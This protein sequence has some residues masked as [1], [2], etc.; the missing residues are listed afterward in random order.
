[1]PRRWEVMDSATDGWAMGSDD[2]GNKA[3]DGSAMSRCTARNGR[4]FAMDGLAIKRWTAKNGRLGN[5]R[6]DNGQL[7][8]KALDGSAIRRWTARGCC[9]GGLG[10]AAMESL[11]WTT[12]CNGRLDNR[13]LDGLQ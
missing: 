7:C 2:S 8:D 3:L 12:A 6:H 11:R 10:D 5:G 1:M 4:R 13:A 9:N